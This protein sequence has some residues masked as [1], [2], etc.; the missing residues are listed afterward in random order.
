MLIALLMPLV[1]AFAKGFEFGP[2]FSCLILP[3]N[4]RL[5]VIYSHSVT[6]ERLQAF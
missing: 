5:N 3:D 2:D 6:A 4:N 1:A